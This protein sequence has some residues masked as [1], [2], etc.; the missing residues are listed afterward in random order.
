[1]RH[2]VFAAVLLGL[3]AFASATVYFS[4]K[5]D[6]G[7]ES[8]WVKSKNKVAEGTQGDWNWTAGKFYNDANEDKGIQTTPDARFYQI[9][10]EFPKFSNKGKD[11]VLQYSVKHEQNIDCGGGYIKILPSGLDQSNFGG[12]SPY[13]IMFGPDV[14]G[15]STRKTHLIF[16]HNGKNHLVKKEI[17]CEL[18]EFTHLYTLILHPDNTYEVQ[19]DGK[20]AQKGNL[21]DDFDILPPR[22]I[23][24][25]KASKPADWVDEREIPDPTDVKPAGW[26]DI[27]KEIVDPEAKK[28]EDWDDELDGEWE[29][30]TIPNPEYKGE[31][32]AKM[33]PN[34]AYKGEWVHPKIANPDFQDNDNLYLYE[35]NKF[36]GFELW[37]VKSGSIFDNILVTDSTA[38]AEKWAELTKKTQEGEKKMK[39]KAD[40][41]QRKADEEARKNAPA[42]AEEG[43][44]EEDEHAGHDHSKDEL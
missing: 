3:I 2:T 36:V 43:E 32:R 28:P 42:E 41:E 15:S 34:P 8:R 23:P 25:P 9:S 7:W 22:E 14:C 5:F 38:E 37:Q 17:R 21:K 11:L 4:E 1:M 12:D 10:A 16:T 39:E 6:D 24:D 13:S 40:E 20:E 27:P 18:D 44:E 26:D 35:D 19:I 31:W 29:A 33:I 30:P